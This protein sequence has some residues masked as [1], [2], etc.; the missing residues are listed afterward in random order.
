MQSMSNNR[1]KVFPL[2]PIS[3][4]TNEAVRSHVG[5][6][7][8]AKREETRIWN[9]TQ[10]TEYSSSTSPVAI[11]LRQADHPEQDLGSGMSPGDYPA[12]SGGL[13]RSQ[14]YAYLKIGPSTGALRFFAREEALFGRNGRYFRSTSSPIHPSSHRRTTTHAT[15]CTLICART[16]QR[17]TQLNSSPR[18]WPSN[19]RAAIN[20]FCVNVLCRSTRRTRPQ[21]RRH[22]SARS[23]AT[24]GHT[25]HRAA[26]GGR[27]PIRS[28]AS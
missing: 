17:A 16:V 25:G 14:G 15:H 3:H 23:T 10:P 5:P 11:R 4:S 24:S 8:S 6:Q 21:E 19:P 20:A 22:E 12:P 27:P 9:W 1:R 26:A 28:G 13:H 7:F 2:S 18:Q